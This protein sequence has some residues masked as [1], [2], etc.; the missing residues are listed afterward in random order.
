[1]HF[2][3]HWSGSRSHISDD[4]ASVAA[5][6]EEEEEEAEAEEDDDEDERDEKVVGTR[7]W[8]D[9]EGRHTRRQSRCVR[10]PGAYESVQVRR[11]VKRSAERQSLLHDNFI[12]VVP[13]RVIRIE[14]V[15][16]KG[17]KAN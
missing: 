1:M 2:Q 14:L 16:R 17:K 6:E 5:A 10:L 11:D 8:F 9:E 13:S 4:G 12:G 15:A 3:S 7:C